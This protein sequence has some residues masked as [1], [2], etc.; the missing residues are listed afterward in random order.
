MDK[1]YLRLQPSEATVT[2]AAAQIYAAY[3]AAGRVPDPDL[4]LRLGVGR[5]LLA[6]ARVGRKK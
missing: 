5:R 3:I 4:V 6:E 1:T 2:Q